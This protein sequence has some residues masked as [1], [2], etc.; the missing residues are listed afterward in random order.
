MGDTEQI[1]NGELTVVV[2]AKRPEPGHVKTRL[3]TAGGLDADR[4]AELAWAMLACTVERV[5]RLGRVVLAVSPDGAGPS[6]AER[7]E[8]VAEVIVV[9]QGAGDLGDR[10]ARVWATLGGRVPIAFFGTD[11]PDLPV[12]HLAALRDGLVAADVVVGPT[13]DGG[14]WGLGTRR[15]IPDIF[16]RI[17]W[18][19]ET[20]YDRTCARVSE[21]DLELGRLPGWHDVDLPDDLAAMRERLAGVR[22]DRALDTLGAELARLVDSRGE[23]PR[24]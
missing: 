17:D 18:G 8:D 22:G 19:T 15:H 13:S 11:S 5:S 21:L 20:V 2:M 14:Y 6:M 3:V 9:D 24:P 16:A 1:A 4:A 23:A 10:L 12:G 7:L